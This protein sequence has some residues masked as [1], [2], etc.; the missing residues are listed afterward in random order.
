[1]RGQLNT[2]CLADPQPRRA[3]ISLNILF[4]SSG[5]CPLS[6]LSA[7]RRAGLRAFGASFTCPLFG[8]SRTEIKF[9]P[10]SPMCEMETF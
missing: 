2:V 4:V 1:M 3:T 9:R 5:E 10:K 6:E 7:A 8:A